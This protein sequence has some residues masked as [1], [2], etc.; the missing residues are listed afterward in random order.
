[1]AAK[2]SD[3][4]KNPEFQRVVQ[5]FLTTPPKPHK[6]LGKKAK[7]GR[8]RAASAKPKTS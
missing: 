2:A 8:E 5:H 6:P 7:K 3:P 1:M 4:T